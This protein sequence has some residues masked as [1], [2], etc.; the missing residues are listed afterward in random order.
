MVH[1][2]MALWRN[3]EPRLET[4]TQSVLQ[5]ERMR[6][7]YDEI[8]SW[9]GYQI[10]PLCPLPGLAARL[11]VG[12][13]HYKD[14][15]GRFGLGS[16]KALG[17]AYAVLRYICRRLRALGLGEP[18]FAQLREGRYREQVKAL[19]VCCATDGNHGRSVAWG[20][21]LFGC[22]CVIY[23]HETVSE[24]RAQAIADYGA[25]VERIV[26]SYDDAVRQV[27]LDADANGWQV[28]SDTSYE[29][30]T[31]VP[32]QV[33]TGYTVMVG[34]AVE[35]F[36]D[37]AGPTHVLVQGGVGGVAAAVFAVMLDAFPHASFIVVE[38]ENAACLYE[39]ARA[40][41][42]V[43]LSGDIDTVMAGLCCGEPSHLAWELLASCTDFF[44]TVSDDSAMTAMRT[45]AEGI[46][47]DGPLVAG[48]SAVAGIAALE[49][50]SAY[51]DYKRELGLDANSRVL[52]F[53]TEGATDPEQYRR[54]VGRSAEDVRRS[55]ESIGR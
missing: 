29:G 14:E 12:A 37:K 21:N 13:L 44:L 27:A 43:A 40:G 19:T 4:Y 3:A 28:I 39:S 24:Y 41:R 7:A 26:G 55:R 15:S 11:G 34:E 52:V 30:Y 49:V 38:P 47:G 33:M 35:Q 32:E 23:V 50:L 42:R 9:P 10:T 2:A 18:S 16:F 6:E 48:E 8:S 5:Q 36:P 31:D 20:A 51:P 1:E 17:G 46:D 54:I 45:L 53:G 22:K 25:R